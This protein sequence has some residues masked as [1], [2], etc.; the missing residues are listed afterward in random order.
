MCQ[1]EGFYDASVKRAKAKTKGKWLPLP[2]EQVNAAA[3]WGGH[4]KVSLS[5]L[6]PIARESFSI[7]FGSKGRLRS[8]VLHLTLDPCAPQVDVAL[9]SKQ[10]LQQILLAVEKP[11][12][13]ST[14][15]TN[16]F[17]SAL[18]WMEANISGYKELQQHQLP[19]LLMAIKKAEVTGN[20]MKAVECV[21]ET[22]RKKVRASIEKRMCLL[23]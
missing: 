11:D 12:E 15:A 23:R 2:L 7:R 1:V 16:N 19:K 6:H 10:M 4:L 5:L 18:L 21:E 8:D 14:A 3:V 17:E 9:M 13:L 20:L 22:W